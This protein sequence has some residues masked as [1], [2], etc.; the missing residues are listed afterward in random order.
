MHHAVVAISIIMLSAGCGASTAV[1]QGEPVPQP[2]T[3]PM[4]VAQDFADDATV[5]ERSGAAGRALECDGAPYNGGG[6][7]YRDGLE[8]VQGSPQEALENWLEREGFGLL[9]DTGY[10][11]EREDDDRV[12]LSY[13]VEEGTK[14]AVIAADGVRD[15]N[16]DEGWGVESWAQCDPAELPGR[17]TDALGIGVWE[18][19]S[20]NRVP[21]TDVHSFSGPEH[22]D[23]QDI[24]FL[25]VGPEEKADQ[26]LR[27]TTGALAELLRTAYAAD[28]TLP[29]D[30]TDTG[31]R[32]NGRQLWLDADGRAAY[33]V[34]VDD[35]ADVERW[36]AA[37]E[38]IGCA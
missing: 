19:A 14:V 18:D 20:G 26:Y 34:S 28:A 8:S 4:R 38:P 27:D 31:L 35:P 5:L 1:V 37:K 25:V 32:R 10:R 16:D 21:V 13:D 23:W 12:L 36:P 29:A 2:Y 24:T 33:L 17:V 11:I 22:C 3:G 7:D 9:P 30:A 6:G 15:Y